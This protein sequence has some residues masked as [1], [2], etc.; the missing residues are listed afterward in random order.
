MIS[1]NHGPIGALT[2]S[3]TVTTLVS[4]LDMPKFCHQHI[5][6]GITGW[7]HLAVMTLQ[8]YL[9]ITGNKEL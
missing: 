4:P 7:T 3:M 8:Q 9:E 6:S 5:S 2:P 1:E